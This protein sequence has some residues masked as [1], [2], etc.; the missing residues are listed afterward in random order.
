MQVEKLVTFYSQESNSR[1]TALRRALTRK[2]PIR[3]QHDDT[4]AQ[5]KYVYRNLA[6][7]KAEGI[8][9]PANTAHAIGSGFGQMGYYQRHWLR[10]QQAQGVL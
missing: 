4:K 10:K 2:G 8:K 1:K 9:A 6:G 3:N 7:A 5:R